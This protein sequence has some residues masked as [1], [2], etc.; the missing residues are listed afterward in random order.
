MGVNG[1]YG[2]YGNYGRNGNYGRGWEHGLSADF[3]EEDGVEGPCGG[4]V[5][6]EDGVG[7]R[8]ES[9]EV[10]PCIVG[11]GFVAEEPSCVGMEARDEEA[12]VGDGARFLFVVAAEVEPC[13]VPRLTIHHRNHLVHDL[14]PT[15]DGEEVVGV[16][17]GCITFVG[18]GSCVGIEAEC[19]RS[20]ED[21]VAECGDA[22]HSCED[23]VMVGCVLGA[24][25]LRHPVGCVCQPVGSDP[26]SCWSGAR[27]E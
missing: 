16:L 1:N 18:D 11:E 13:L 22:F 15:H 7:R 6:V 9:E 20:G 21:A 4:V 5:G 23:F 2:N 27:I 3:L 24:F 14:K 17:E 8:F 26:Q 12:V 19:F 10:V 25:P